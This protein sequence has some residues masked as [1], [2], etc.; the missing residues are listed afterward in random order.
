MLAGL[1]QW[2][3]CRLRGSLASEGVAL[4][5]F[6]IFRF[7]YDEVETLLRC[8]V[9]S[10]GSAAVMDAR[11]ASVAEDDDDYFLVLEVP[12]SLRGSVYFW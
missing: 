6:G 7:G 8:K 9:H 2:R 3:S 10:I 11:W 1:S 12:P 5:R 4:W